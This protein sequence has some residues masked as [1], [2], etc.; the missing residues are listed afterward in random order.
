M[1]QTFKD[2]S[3]KRRSL[4]IGLLILALVLLTAT[5]G[6]SAKY[7]SDKRAFKGTLIL[8]SSDLVIFTVGP[9]VET[10]AAGEDITVDISLSGTY[11]AHSMQ[12]RLSYDMDKLELDL[13]NIVK[14]SV[15]NA[16]TGNGGW[17]EIKENPQHEVI[18]MAI[19]PGESF[20]VEG[21][22]VSL[23][24]HVK[25]TAPAGEAKVKLTVDELKYVPLDST[26]ESGQ[27]DVPYEVQ[28][29]EFII[30]IAAGETG[31][32]DN[33]AKAKPDP[34]ATPEPE[35]PDTDETDEPTDPTD[36]V[37]PT[38]DPD[39]STEP[40]I[41]PENPDDSIDPIIPTDNPDPEDPGVGE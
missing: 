5:I 38:N 12:L 40:V 24:F 16:I 30:P 27:I 21:K 28:P 6:V 39:D 19:S 14:E 36:P 33:T 18:I 26:D 10:A 11:A 13:S 32:P 23:K 8:P 29:E 3:P 20:S 41:T 17:V 9:E 34:T 7:V 37:D 25:D 4:R 31:E 22:I 1:T 35:D 15:L 2:L